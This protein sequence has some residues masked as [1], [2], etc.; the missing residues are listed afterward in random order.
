VDGIE[1]EREKWGGL[2]RRVFRLGARLCALLSTRLVFDAEEISVRWNKMFGRSGSVIP[3]GGTVEQ[4]PLPSGVDLPAGRYVLYV[5]RLVPENSVLNF[6]GAARALAADYPVVIVGSAGYGGPI[7][8]QV[9]ALAAE[10]TNVTWLGHVGNDTLLHALWSNAGVYFHGH[11]VGG[12]NPALVQAMACGAP[13]VARDTVFNREVLDGAGI[14]TSSD[15]ESIARAIRGLLEDRDLR[16][17]LIEAG[18]RRVRERYTWPQ[19][20]AAYE[21]LLSELVGRAEDH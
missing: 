14:F 7:E 12:T 3:Y 19:V 8:D 6:L 20:C 11:T 21:R 16:A 5:A 4:P 9:R 10:Q 17:E 13:V 2:A 1:W 18:V 15:A